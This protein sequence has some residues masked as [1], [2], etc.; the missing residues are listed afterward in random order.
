MEKNYS[1]IDFARYFSGEASPEEIESMDAW[2]K[3]SLKI[4][5]L[6]FQSYTY[7]DVKL[8]RSLFYQAL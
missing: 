7:I 4:A 8:K 3:S 1:D 6:A 2:C 5:T